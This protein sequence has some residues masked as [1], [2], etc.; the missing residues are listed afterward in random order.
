MQVQSRRKLV[1]RRA[2][3]VCERESEQKEVGWETSGVCVCVCVSEQKEV[4]W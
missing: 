4:G 3:C 1:G 2:V